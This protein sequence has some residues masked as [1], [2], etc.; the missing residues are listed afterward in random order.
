MAISIV[1]LF[2]SLSGIKLDELDVLGNK[3][4]IQ[5]P[6]YITASLWAAFFYWLV[7]YFQLLHDSGNLGIRDR[8]VS[9][10]F[11]STSLVVRPQ[12]D[13][14][15]RAEMRSR[16]VP[17]TVEFWVEVM[18]WKSKPS[19]SWPFGIRAF[20]CGANY[21]VQD[22][23]GALIKGNVAKDWELKPLYGMFLKSWFDG[24]WFVFAK[25][26]L[27]TEYILPPLLAFSVLAICVAHALV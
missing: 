10:V 27:G 2:V 20:E 1:N 17:D 12:F 24:L 15:V 16:K 13:E 22:S 18:N 7:R 26:S 14:Y 9:I 25:S 4:T 5:N 21:N 3:F 6:H 19:M 8:Y 11:L 23:A